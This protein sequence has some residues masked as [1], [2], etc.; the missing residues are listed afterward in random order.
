M[1]GCEY[2][3]LPAKF[4][5]ISFP[6]SSSFPSPAYTSTFF[7]RQS[8]ELHLEPKLSSFA[9]CIR[10]MPSQGIANT[11]FHQYGTDNPSRVLSM[12]APGQG[13]RVEGPTVYT[14]MPPQ[15]AAQ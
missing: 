14:Y 11:S 10:K 15:I 7:P 3:F 5:V 2:R 13:Q 8:L 6:L 12:P 4:A 9:T 1:P